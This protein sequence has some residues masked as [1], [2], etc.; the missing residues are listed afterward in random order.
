[1]GIRVRNNMKLYLTVAVVATPQ[2]GTVT[3]T[4]Q[5]RA[6]SL[7]LGIHRILFEAGRVL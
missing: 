1:M 2:I 4:V 7:R 6:A 3:V 5:L